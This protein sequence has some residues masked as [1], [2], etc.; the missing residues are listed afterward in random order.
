MLLQ[1]I[2]M[3][4]AHFKTYLRQSDWIKKYIFPGAELAS[5]AEILR[6]TARCTELQLAHAEDIGLHYAETLAEWR[7]RFV[8]KKSEVHSLGFDQRF[9]RMWEFYLVYCEGGFRERYIGDA[10]ILLTKV[11]S[12]LGRPGG[13]AHR[14]IDDLRTPVSRT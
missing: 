11:K 1:T 9:L 3:N 2:T 8:A 13:A 6:S 7:R 12:E 5:I 14:P 10:Q 4:E